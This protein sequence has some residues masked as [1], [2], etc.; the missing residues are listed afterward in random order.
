[1]RM[2]LLLCLLLL[3][4]MPGQSYNADTASE[5]V[6][7]IPG[8]TKKNGKLYFHGEEVISVSSMGGDDPAS[9]DSSPSPS[10]DD[11]K[12]GSADYMEMPEQ[13]LTTAGRPQATY[14][15]DAKW[16]AEQQANILQLYKEVDALATDI[17][18]TS[19]RVKTALWETPQALFTANRDRQN[20]RQRMLKR[21]REMMRKKKLYTGI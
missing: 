21:M 6:L 1:M 5:G 4:I 7:D 17:Q 12:A 19:K 20:S 9:S 2:L 15:R 3:E 8:M 18:L 13:K 11:D 16:L 14:V 10:I